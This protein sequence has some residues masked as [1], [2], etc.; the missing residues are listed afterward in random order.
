[1]HSVSRQNF[2][3]IYKILLLLLAPFLLSACVI[4]ATPQRYY[5][6]EGKEPSYFTG[7]VD[8]LSG[9]VSIKVD[10]NAVLQ[11]KV[12]R[13]SDSLKLQGQYKHHKL[14]AECKMVYCTNSFSC[15][16]YSDEQP[17]VLMEFGKP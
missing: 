3:N 12:A 11:G 16:I 1:M 13:F 6:S 15:F 10:N 7:E 14:S 8:G 4:Q 17:A 9:D 5:F 2:K